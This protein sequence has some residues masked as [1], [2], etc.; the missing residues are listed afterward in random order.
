[1]LQEKKMGSILFGGTYTHNLNM[2]D[3]DKNYFEILEEHDL[4][5]SEY[6]DSTCE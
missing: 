1:M 5:K 3:S 6:I 2:C 4:L